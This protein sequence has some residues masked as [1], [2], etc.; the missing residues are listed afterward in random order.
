MVKYTKSNLQKL[1]LLF[2]E[3]EYTIRYEK[4]NFQSGYCVVQARKIAVINKFFDTEARINCLLD[5]LSTI[6]VM[7]NVMS[8]PSKTLYKSILKNEEY[9]ANVA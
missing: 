8:A 7:D 9:R 3:Q 4:G 1:E 5:I 2:K 6:I